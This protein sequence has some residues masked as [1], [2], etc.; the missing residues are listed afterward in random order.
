MNVMAAGDFPHNNTRVVMQH[1]LK[2]GC[3]VC[4]ARGRRVRE[5]HTW[6]SWRVSFSCRASIVG[7]AYKVDADRNCR[8]ALYNN[9]THRRLQL[10]VR[11]L[12]RTEDRS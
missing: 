9:L 2:N 3:P 1:L 5:R 11:N 10:L 4:G 7:Y 12:L 8:K 6:E